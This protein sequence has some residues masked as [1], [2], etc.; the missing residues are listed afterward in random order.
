[1]NTFY[2]KKKESKVQTQAEHPAAS[3]RAPKDDAPYH[4]VDSAM[5]IGKLHFQKLNDL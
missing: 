1:M 2:V 5:N 3:R 4:S